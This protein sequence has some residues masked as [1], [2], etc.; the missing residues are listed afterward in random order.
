[1]A[2][3]ATPPLDGIRRAIIAALFSD[4][5][6]FEHLALKGGNALRLIYDLQERTSLDLDLSLDTDLKDLE[7]TRSR[8][9]RALCDRLDSAGYMSFDEAMVEQPPHPVGRWG[10]YRLTFKVIAKRDLARFAGDLEALRRN[11]LPFG[12]LQQKT[13]R[14]EISK[15]EYCVGKIQ[16]ELDSQAIYVYSPEMIA[17]EKLRALC[18]QLREY[19]HRG[20][21]ARRAR[22]FYDIHTV[23]TRLSLQLEAVDRVEMGRAIFGAKDVPIPLL[24]KIRSSYEFHA[25]DWPSVQVS[26]GRNLRGFDFYFD[27]VVDLAERLESLWH[28]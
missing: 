14:V 21:P 10:G 12:P 19:P 8:L 23:V 13:W 18:Q 25:S 5:E 15:Y 1:M 9:A 17:I 24:R 20:H 26:S 11:A 22:D 3:A 27:F 2:T 4:D 6:L 7:G 28:E 16:Y